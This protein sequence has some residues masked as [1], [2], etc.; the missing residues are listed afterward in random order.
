MKSLLPALFM[1]FIPENSAKNFSADNNLRGELK[2]MLE[3]FTGAHL[4]KLVRVKFRGTRESSSE[5]FKILEPCKN[6]TKRLQ[7]FKLN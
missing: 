1:C 4:K 5:N 7:S 2:N 6:K 3:K